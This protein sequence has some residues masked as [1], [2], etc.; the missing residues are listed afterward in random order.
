MRYCTLCV[1]SAYM[2]IHFRYV[3]N[4]L[5]LNIS[6][7]PQ[8]GITHKTYD[9]RHSWDLQQH[10]QQFGM[11]SVIRGGLQQHMHSKAINKM[12]LYQK[13]R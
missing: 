4:I 2:E 11:M 3:I 9:K 13:V 5:V 10:T 6:F 1:L 7:W 8:F 12:S